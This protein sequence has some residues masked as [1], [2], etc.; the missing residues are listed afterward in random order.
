M[1]ELTMLYD[2]DYNAWIKYTTNLLKTK[3]FAQ[4]D[5]EHLLE[6]LEYMGK[7]EQRE[8]ESRL[9][10]LLS[11]LLKLQYQYQQLSERWK[12]FDG[13]SWK[14][15]ITTQR[16]EINIHLRKHPGVKKFFPKIIWDAY[17]DARELATEETGLSMDTF[18]YVCS[19]TQ[20]QI[21]DKTF[22]PAIMH[23]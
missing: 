2:E 6:E 7:D 12:E 1:N 4:L 3:R 17:Q 23:S 13:K 11:H 8:V 18:P 9:R 21:F 10:V 15:T 16:V 5:I 22:Y 20:Q 19:Y 14:S